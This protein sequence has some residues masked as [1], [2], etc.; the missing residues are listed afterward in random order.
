MDYKRLLPGVIIGVIVLY[1]ISKLAK[2]SSSPQVYN[3]LL[4]TSTDK[5]DNRDAA[6]TSGFSTLASLGLGQLKMQGE[7]NQLLA[8]IDL[9]KQRFANTLDLARIQDAGATNRLMAQLGDRAYDRALQEKALDQS[10]ALA[11]TGQ[12]SGGLGNLVGSILNAI[13]GNQSPQSRPSSGSGSGAGIP[14]SPPLNSSA[15][16]RPNYNLIARWLDKN[17]NA[18]LTD[19]LYQDLG[20]ASPIDLSAYDWLTGYGQSGFDYWQG[21]YNNSDLM[22]EPVGSV[23]SGY[24]LYDPRGWFQDWGFSSEADLYDYYAIDPDYFL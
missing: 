21:Y 16:R 13:K 24:S 14:S 11:Q 8:S 5:P 19:P 2:G 12:V 9:A 7:Q 22:T 20:Y 23:T 1:A 4:P 18:P 6:R 10:F 17:R 15:A 3:A